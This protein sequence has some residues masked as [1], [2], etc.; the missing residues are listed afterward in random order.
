[1]LLLWYNNVMSTRISGDWDFA[2][3]LAGHFA[4]VTDPDNL[5]TLGRL[6]RG[7]V[8]KGTEQQWGDDILHIYEPS[9]AEGTLATIKT[10]V[11]S[12]AA[13]LSITGITLTKD[14][15]LLRVIN[16][17]GPDEPVGSGIMV[18][19][20]DYDGMYTRRL[21]SGPALENS[22]KHIAQLAQ[23]FFTVAYPELS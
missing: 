13:T 18:E 8:L 14:R 9:W 23:L 11:N 3:V 17:F 19:H 16:K 5:H 1:M 12:T 21:R 10:M 15:H 4:P 6:A 2:D 7:C 22:Q 20:S